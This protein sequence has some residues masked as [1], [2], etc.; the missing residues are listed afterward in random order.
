M[1]YFIFLTKIA[2][3]VTNATPTLNI[4]I[5]TPA[6]SISQLINGQIRPDLDQLQA[7]SYILSTFDYLT[8]VEALI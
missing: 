8:N 3:K 4:G 1:N 7:T 6:T 2:K 5:A